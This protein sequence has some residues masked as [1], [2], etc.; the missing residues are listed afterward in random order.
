[1]EAEKISFGAGTTYEKFIP[2]GSRGVIRNK[3]KISESTNIKEA[4]WVMEIEVKGYLL[5]T[6]T[7]YNGTDIYSKL[8][9]NGKVVFENKVF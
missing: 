4:V 6:R 7:N 2:S 1:M 8:T 9:K 3:E 5:E